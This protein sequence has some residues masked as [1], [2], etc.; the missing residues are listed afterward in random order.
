M[1]GEL[2]RLHAVTD[3]DILALPDLADRARA[4]AAIGPV[5]LHVRAKSLPVRRLIAV[6]QAFQ[7]TGSPVFINDRADVASIVGAAGLHLPATGLP[8]AAARRVVGAEMLIG[9][10]THSPSEARAAVHGGATYAFLGPMWETASHPEREPL[11]PA[12]IGAARPAPI[13]A[14]GG[15]TPERARIAHQAGAWGVAARRALWLADDPGSA[16]REMLI[17]LGQAL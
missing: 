17:S 13:I 12:A 5:A 4:L 6:A 14:I 1:T 16:A 15:I 2:P 8:L 9:R 3:D 11:G 7:A 10:S